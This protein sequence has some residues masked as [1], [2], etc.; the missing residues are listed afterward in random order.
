MSAADVATNGNGHAAAA[1]EGQRMLY[2]KM[3]RIKSAM[4]LAG[5]PSMTMTQDAVVAMTAFIQYVAL[6]WFF[7]CR[8][9]LR[10]QRK[11]QISPDVL[12]QAKEN[13]AALS[14]ILPYQH[15][16]LLGQG[17]RPIYTNALK[18]RSEENR[19]KR[20]ANEERQR[21]AEAKAAA[22]L[23]ARKR[24]KTSRK[25]AVASDEESSEASQQQ[26]EETATASKK[27]KK[28]GGKKH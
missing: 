5:G 4:K 1:E 27:Q 2:F 12:A 24:K 7:R 28:S 8:R 25:A 15:N 6:R 18:A 22:E 17:V 14:V 20:E 9:V 16:E 13:D 10:D 11:K 23:A 21:E 19:Q 3:S 26:Q